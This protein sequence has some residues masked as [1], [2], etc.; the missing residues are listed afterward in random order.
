MAQEEL[1]TVVWSGDFE[2]LPHL[3]ESIITAT[4][5]HSTPNKSA[6][7]AITIPPVLPCTPPAPPSHTNPAKFVSEWSD[8]G[9]PRQVTNLIEKCLTSQIDA[10]N[11][12]KEMYKEQQ[13]LYKEQRE[14]TEIQKHYKKKLKN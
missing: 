8:S 14:F 1:A 11:T 2:E 5:H 3:E 6:G 9:T 12:Y 13:L 4:T 7:M 10:W